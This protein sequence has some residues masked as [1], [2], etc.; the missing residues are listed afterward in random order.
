LLDDNGWNQQGQMYML[1]MSDETE[2]RREE[3]G[4]SFFDK[5][6]KDEDPNSWAVIVHCSD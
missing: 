5:W 4:R 6:I 2:E 3:W 1:G